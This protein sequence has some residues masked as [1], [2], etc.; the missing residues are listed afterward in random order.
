MIP[1]EGIIPPGG[2]HYIERHQG[3]E[4]KIV[5]HSYQ[6]VAEQLLKFRIANKIAL[7]QP[8]DDVRG[9]VCTNW[10]HFCTD[11]QP[12]VAT[13]TTSE[14]SFTVAVMQW[15]ATLWDRQARVPKNLVGDAEAQRR[16]AICQGCPLQRDW[17][18]YGCGSCVASVRQ[19]GY[20]YRAGRE[21]GIKITGCA[22][23]KQDNTTAVF[24]HPDALPEATEAQRASLPHQC[25]RK[26]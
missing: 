10:P 3:T 25:W 14:P 19:K 1:K 17:A 15:M 22:V 6:D 23:L 12:M 4:T 24:A 7:G 5:G 20:V 16:A 13:R 18:D 26:R 9:F 11:N 21:T 8:L 2:H